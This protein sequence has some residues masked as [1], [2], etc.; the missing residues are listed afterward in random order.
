MEIENSGVLKSAKKVRT[1]F[2]PEFSG[3]KRSGKPTFETLSG[4]FCE[5]TRHQGGAVRH[6]RKGPSG[7]GPARKSPISGHLGP[8]ILHREVDD[9]ELF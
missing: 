9:D 1:P 6:G 5:F 3:D 4:S 8:T 2:K 7:M